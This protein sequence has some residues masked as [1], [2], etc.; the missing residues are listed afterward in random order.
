MSNAEFRERL[1]GYIHT[2][3]LPVDKYSHQPRLYALA[4]SL[5]G[6]LVYDDDVLFAAA[7]IHDLGVFVGHR[8]TELAALAAWDHIAYVD[9]HAPQILSELGFPKDKIS[10]VL[11]AVRTHLPLSE[12]ETVEG[13]LLRDADLLEQLGA[14]GILRIV[15]KV[16]RDTRFIRFSDAVA[17]L[18]NNL[19]D[20]PGKLK[21][22]TAR[23]AAVSRVE[24]LRCFLEGA[25]REAGSVPW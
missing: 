16:G 24:V 1:V 18:R 25:V 21:L 5:A 2:Q 9:R 10:L 6:N 23:E 7:W 12:P 19:N 15:S 4:R 8:P 11:A 22:E 14:V 13:V 20:L 3:A 17:T